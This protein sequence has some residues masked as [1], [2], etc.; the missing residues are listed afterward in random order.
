MQG[1][2]NMMNK[3]GNSWKGKCYE[4][5]GVFPLKRSKT[6]YEPLCMIVDSEA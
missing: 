2:E 1:L 5:R 4:E 3:T 6:G